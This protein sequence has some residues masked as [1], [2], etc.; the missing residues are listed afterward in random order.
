M[1]SLMLR[2]PKTQFGS[3]PG[4]CAR[5][6]FQAS[7][8]RHSAVAVRAGVGEH[9]ID[10]L[11]QLQ[12][13]LAKAVQLEDYKLAA[14]LRDNIRR[15]DPAARAAPAITHVKQQLEQAVEE[16]EYEASVSGVAAIS[17]CLSDAVLV[18]LGSL[19]GLLPSLVVAAVE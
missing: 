11:R 14:Q 5:R 7:R 2:L 4:F 18:H 12:A 13:A 15:L 1:T 17:T 16:E 19:L 6:N 8:R 3:T 9:H 10:E